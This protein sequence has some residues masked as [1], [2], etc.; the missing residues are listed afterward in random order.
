MNTSFQ[1]IDELLN[2]ITDNTDD[3]IGSIGTVEER[4]GENVNDVEM[5]LQRM[6]ELGLLNIAGQDEDGNNLYEVV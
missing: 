1:S 2:H 5:F 6:V 4:D 3:I